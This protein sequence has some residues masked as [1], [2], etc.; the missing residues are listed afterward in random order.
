MNRG[1]LLLVTLGLALGGCGVTTEPQPVT[2]D[3][4]G[5][6][7]GLL[8]STSTAS[9]T[10]TTTDP[11][12]DGRP[13]EGLTVCFH[14]GTRV[15][16]V[17]RPGREPGVMQALAALRAGPT[18]DEASLGLST[19][20]FDPSIATGVRMTGGIATVELGPA[21]AD[22]GA[23]VQYDVIVETVCTLTSQPGVGQVAF[24]V[25]GE[26]V[27]VPREDGS[28]SAEPVSRDDYPGLGR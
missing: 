3:D 6:P 25:D 12:P 17:V 26:R 27:E 22:A 9:T 8:T 28:L 20:V 15:V 24:E 5:V 14:R 13:A 21:F 19:A 1:A 2:V 10:T 4:D 18:A 11:P 7:F 23:A 16:P